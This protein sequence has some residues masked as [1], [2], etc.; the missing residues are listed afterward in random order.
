MS[1]FRSLLHR[2]V[3]YG[4]WLDPLELAYCLEM[5]KASDLKLVSAGAN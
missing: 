2:E 5:A 1:I 3:R 4:C